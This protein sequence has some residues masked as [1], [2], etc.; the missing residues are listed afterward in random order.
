MINRKLLKQ[1]QELQ[2]RLLKAQEEL[3]QLT[4]EASAGGG[5][6]TVV[7]TGQPRVKEVRISAEAAADPELLPDLIVAAVNEALNKSQ[8]MA[9][10]RLGGLGLPGM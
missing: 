2:S 10:R 8:E 6:V 3:A 4:V 9:G 1:A 7:M 5:A